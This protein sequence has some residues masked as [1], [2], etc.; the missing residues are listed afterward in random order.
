MSRSYERKR[1][2][3]A[4]IPSLDQMIPQNDEAKKET[5][6]SDENDIDN[7]KPTICSLKRLQVSIPDDIRDHLARQYQEDD[8]AIYPES[9]E[10]IG[11]IL[12]AMKT[13]PATTTCRVNLIQGTKE[14]IL[15][16]VETELQ[17]RE[18][19]SFF[20]VQPQSD[21]PDV[22]CVDQKDEGSNSN[23]TEKDTTDRLDRTGPATPSNATPL[24]PSWTSRGDLGWPAAHRVVIVDRFCGEAVLRGAHIFVRGIMAADRGIQPQETVAVFA[25]IRPTIVSTT[26]GKSHTINRGLTLEQYK[27]RTCVYLGLGVTQCSRTDFFRLPKGIGIQM[28]L[29]IEARVGPVLPPISGILPSKIYFQNLPSMVVAHA[30]SPQ[31]G[32][33]II[34]MCAAPGGKTSHVASL[35]KNDATIVACDVS[36]RKMLSVQAMFQDMGA[37]CITPIALNTTDCVIKDEKKNEDGSLKWHSVQEVSRIVFHVYR[38]TVFLVDLCP[39]HFL[40][41]HFLS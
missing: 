3:S 25:D 27:G 40:S 28:K 17:Q 6:P 5:G 36:R 19:D 12:L 33:T 1:P 39:I 2:T 30:L 26:T 31:P 14:S 35:V 21:F 22:L 20:E 37:T 38:L 13:P 11:R 10:R 4:L 15:K 7:D 34:D 23:N 41:F 24:F 9:Y 8:A 16:E 29:E 18:L 32:D